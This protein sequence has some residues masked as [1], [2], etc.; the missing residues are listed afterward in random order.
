MTSGYAQQV[1]RRLGFSAEQLEELAI[2]AAFADI[3]MKEAAGAC[4]EKPGCLT[5]GSF[6]GWPGIRFSARSYAGLWAC[7]K[8]YGR[9]C[10]AIM[11]LG[12]AVAIRR[13]GRARRS[14][15]LPLSSA[16]AVPFPLCC[17]PGLTA[18]SQVVCGSSRLVPRGRPPLA[19]FRCTGGYRLIGNKHTAYSIRRN[20]LC[21]LNK[22]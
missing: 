9:R 2:A 11:K 5:Y 18:G 14:P 16:P 19:S 3:A 12:M 20:I 17:F 7:Q 15:C 6:D 22:S 8:V 4:L 1:G 10:F 21:F 13:D